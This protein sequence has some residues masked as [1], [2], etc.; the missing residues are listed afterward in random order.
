MI[1]AGVFLRDDGHDFMIVD[2]LGIIG[3]EAMIAIAGK[4]VEIAL[5]DIAEIATVD[6]EKAAANGDGIEGLGGL[7]GLDGVM[8]ELAGGSGSGMI[9][10]DWLGGGVTGGL[11][12]E[13]DEK[14][15]EKNES[16][17]ENETHWN[18]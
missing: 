5:K 16:G 17:D 4:M 18:M 15:D 13:E 14:E 1:E 7:D 10:D 9:K 11:G 6:E 8:E 2:V 3:D 12:D